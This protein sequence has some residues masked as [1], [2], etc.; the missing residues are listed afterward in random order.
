MPT[1][2]GNK[3]IETI[4]PNIDYLKL[5]PVLEVSYAK[6]IINMLATRQ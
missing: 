2:I 4:N 5:Q 3:K 6:N 1:S